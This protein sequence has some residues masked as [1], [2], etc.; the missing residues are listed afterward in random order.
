MDDVDLDNK[1]LGNFLKRWAD[2][3]AFRAEF[4]GGS[5]MIC[6]EIIIVTSQYLPCSIFTDPALIVALERRFT[7]VD[8]TP[9]EL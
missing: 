9:N 2:H 1:H 6:P 8:L 3:Y 5:R 7:I 4:K